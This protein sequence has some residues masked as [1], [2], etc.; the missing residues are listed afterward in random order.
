MNNAEF[1]L[2]PVVSP[3]L[4]SEL[5]TQPTADVLPEPSVNQELTR[6]DRVKSWI[7]ERKTKLAIGAAAASALV[8]LTINPLEDLK[9]DVMEAA[10]WV[11]GGVAA[12]ELAFVVGAGMMVASVG[13]KVGNPLK[14]KGRIPE[15]AQK[16]NSSILFKAGFVLNTTGAVGDFAVISAGV[17]KDMPVESYPMLS[18]TLL[19]LGVTVAVRKAIMNGINNNIEP[20]DPVAI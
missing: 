3:L 2:H 4:P 8:T 10:P 14:I 16:A 12:S 6:I 13:E 11:G 15:I 1:E 19:D 5:E 20:P 9:E 7:S 17:L 18:L